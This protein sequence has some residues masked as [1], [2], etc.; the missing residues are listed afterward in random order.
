MP[1]IVG[2]I[3]F[4]MERKKAEERTRGANGTDKGFEWKHWCNY[5]AVKPR[6]ELLYKDG[7]C[8]CA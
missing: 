6:Q 4:L 7:V 1:S 8:V 3:G 5:H 2:L